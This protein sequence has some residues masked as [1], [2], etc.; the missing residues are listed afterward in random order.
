MSQF[1]RAKTHLQP[2]AIAANILQSNSAH[3]DQ[4]LLMLGNL[5]QLF[6]HV[7]IEANVR[8]GM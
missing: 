8:Q 6:S 4:V 1:Q 7:A 3:L 5:Y 2:L